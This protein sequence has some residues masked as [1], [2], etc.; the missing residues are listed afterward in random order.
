MSAFNSPYH[1]H[2]YGGPA[3][4]DSPNLIRP[5]LPPSTFPPT[6]PIS[7]QQH[8][9]PL[10]TRP[11][12]QKKRIMKTPISSKV[13]LNEKSG[14]QPFP[15]RRLL[16][17]ALRRAVISDRLFSGFLFHDFAEKDGSGKEIHRSQRFHEQIDASADSFD[18]DVM[19]VV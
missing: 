13:H 3:Q 10:S 15:L 12:R 9:D 18:L 11:P 5:P 8:P 7:L 16:S 19:R 1:H 6:H 4:F 17:C 2:S 14:A